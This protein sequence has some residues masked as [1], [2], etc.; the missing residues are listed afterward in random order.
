MI[1]NGHIYMGISISFNNPS[2]NFHQN[3]NVYQTFLPV[4]DCVRIIIIKSVFPPVG[5]VR[6][7]SS[8]QESEREVSRLKT[9][10]SY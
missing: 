1:K 3:L 2:C 4:V 7:E 8:D 9:R 5:C 6:Q 10:I